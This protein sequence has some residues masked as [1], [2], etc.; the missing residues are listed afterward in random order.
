MLK[1]L[2]PDGVPGGALLYNTTTDKIQVRNTAST[3]ADVSSSLLSTAQQPIV[4]LL[5]YVSMMFLPGLKKL[6]LCLIW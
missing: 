5:K 4:I 1:R 3:F 6:Q 2:T